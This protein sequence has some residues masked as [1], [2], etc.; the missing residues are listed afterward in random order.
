MQLHE[1]RRS[2]PRAGRR[3]RP[4]AA[5]S[6]L[7]LAGA[8]PG[9]GA[10]I[11]YADEGLEPFAGA[12]LDG[13]ALEEVCQSFGG[14]VIGGPFVLADL[15]ASLAIDVTLL[16]LVLLKAL[17]EALRE[18]PAAPVL[19]RAPAPAAPEATPP[20]GWPAL[21]GW[22]AGPEDRAEEVGAAGPE[23]PGWLAAACV[24][25][26]GRLRLES[27]EGRRLPRGVA[28]VAAAAR[29]PGGRVAH[30][31]G[32]DVEL[33]PAAG[34]FP[35]A[36][37][38]GRV[39]G[40]A[41]APDGSCLAAATESGAALLLPLRPD[42]AGPLHVPGAPRGARAVAFDPQGRLLAIGG[43]SGEV[44]VW[45]RDPRW[46]PVTPVGRFSVADLDVGPA[47]AGTEWPEPATQVQVGADGAARADAR[48]VPALAWLDERTLVVGRADG[49]LFRRGL[50]ELPVPLGRRL[51]ASPLAI[52]PAG[53]GLLLGLADGR[54]VLA[55][56]DGASRKDRLLG[57]HEGAVVA[58]A[59]DGA[60]AA[61]A[62]LDGA[63]QTWDLEAGAPLDR[64]DL[65]AIDDLP[66][67]VAL[68][69][70][71]RRLVIVTRRGL[72]LRYGP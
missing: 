33:S 70:G 40:L 29:L 13:E 68:E 1:D 19:P 39:V 45:L 18:E 69:E 47:P 5:L 6:L 34:R 35:G 52:V 15:A 27:V 48:W 72:V 31:R 30:G 42:A 2:S 55:R 37:A 22:P 11:G 7:A 32:V 43:W 58:A 44:G 3:A 9:C 63:V 28:D 41:A 14:V 66:A 59:V 16:P 17:H 12:S 57:R 21:V 36:P 62:G 24:S 71:G 65:A 38:R 53:A 49:A 4:A 26:R 46:S 67:G 25:E 54:V 10:V 60:R 56:L 64:I 61:T 23:V 51:E 8:L 20:P 50:G